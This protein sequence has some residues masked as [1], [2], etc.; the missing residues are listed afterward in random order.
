MT[1][2][3]LLTSIARTAKRKCIDFGK[4]FQHTIDAD[5]SILAKA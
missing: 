4:Q 3:C 5:V 1:R 2:V